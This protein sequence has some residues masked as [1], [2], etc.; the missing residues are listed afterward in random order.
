MRRRTDNRYSNK[1]GRA[2]L[3]RY[4]FSPLCLALFSPSLVD[5]IPLFF[6]YGKEGGNR[7]LTKK[8]IYN[9]HR[10]LFFPIIDAEKQRAHVVGIYRRQI[11]VAT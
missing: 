2:A 1:L 5:M 7:M 11:I 10:S 4:D 6:L 8:Q 9:M 3:S